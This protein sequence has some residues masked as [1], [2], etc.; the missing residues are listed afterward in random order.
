[1]SSSKHENCLIPVHE[2]FGPTVQGEGFWSGSVVSFIRLAG[3][4][5]GCPWCD[6]GYANGGIGLPRYSQKIDSLVS[7]AS[8]RVVVSGGEPFIHSSFPLLIDKLLASGRHVHVET[9]GS[10]YRPIDD[11]AWVT[12]SPKGHINNAYP[13][14]NE[15]W[16]RANEVKLVIANGDEV[17]FYYKWLAEFNG[18][19]FLQPEHTQGD[20]SLQ[21]TLEL[22]YFNPRFRLSLQTHKIIGV[23]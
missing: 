21:K 20:I 10:F 9:S 15:F 22:L 13:V 19:V 11:R 23:L 16:H 2:C 7:G 3:C 4:P 12:L 8:E 1:M 17:A 5:V 14:C 18:P 6:T